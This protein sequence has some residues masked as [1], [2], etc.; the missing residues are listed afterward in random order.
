MSLHGD[1]R[2]HNG[3]L[4]AELLTAKASAQMTLNK[5]TRAEFSEFLGEKNSADSDSRISQQTRLFD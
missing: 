4:D 2:R 5:A 1:W 3:R